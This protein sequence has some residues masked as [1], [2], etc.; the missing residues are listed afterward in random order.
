MMPGPVHTF[1][2]LGR[3]IELLPLV[4]KNLLLQILTLGFYRFWAITRIRRYLWSRTLFQDDPLEY[5]GTG[6]ELF[7]GFLVAAVIVLLPLFGL[8][9]TSGVLSQMGRNGEAQVI[10]GLNA[11][12]VLLLT[13]IAVYRARRYRLNRTVWRGIRCGQ[14]GSAL[15]YALRWIGYGLLTGLTLGLAYPWQAVGL[16][17]YRLNHTYFGSDPLQFDGKGAALFGPWMRIWALSLLALLALFVV[18]LV[19]GFSFAAIPKDPEAVRPAEMLRG[20]GLAFVAVLPGLVALVALYCWYK[21]AELRYVVGRMRYQGLTFRCEATGGQLA[22]LA[23]GNILLRVFTLGLAAPYALVRTARLVARTVAAEGSVDFDR[24][25][26][27]ADMRSTT[28]E[29]L[30]AAINVGEF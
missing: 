15:G 20:V 1:S 3:F 29:G 25:R 11:A 22:W 12:L 24:V 9:V 21:A 23:L 13:P 5:T 27:N 7:L 30:A 4:L 2:H 19:L 14:S 10:N 17:R 28:G 18:P 26:Q 8:G 16:E 6:K